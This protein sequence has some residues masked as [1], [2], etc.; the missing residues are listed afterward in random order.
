MNILQL[1]IV[2]DL[3]EELIKK[4]S[5]TAFMVTHNMRDALKYGNRLIMMN[6]GKI[7]LDV[8]GKEKEKLTINDLLELFN[9]N[10]ELNDSIVLS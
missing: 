10:G 1:L 8:S 3:T 4:N 2:L 7:I 9:E 5:L 6:E